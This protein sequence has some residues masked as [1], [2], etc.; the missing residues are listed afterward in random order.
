M[1]I[2]FDNDKIIVRAVENSDRKGRASNLVV[3]KKWV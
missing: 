3:H 2:G 1:K